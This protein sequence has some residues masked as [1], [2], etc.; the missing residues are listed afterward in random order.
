MNIKLN[1]ILLLIALLCLMSSCGGKHD[2]AAEEQKESK[3][4]KS[5]LQ[6]VWVDAE[7]ESVAFMVKGDTI[8]YPDSTLMP[9]C[10][11]I[12]GDTL[13]LKGG[14]T[15]KYGIVKQSK[16]IFSFRNG[17]G[18][19]IKLVRSVDEEQDLLLFEHKTVQPI[20]QGVKID[21]DSIVTAG[22]KRYHFYTTVNPTSFKVLKRTFNDDGVEVD[23]VYYDNIV[24]LSVFDGNTKVFSGDFRKDHFAQFIE[25]YNGEGLILSDINYIGSKAGALLFEAVIGEPDGISNYVV[26]I[27]IDAKGKISIGG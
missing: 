9:V 11:V 26:S 10:F 1:R 7:S 8:F 20:N 18:E 4:A 23:N 21:R 17:V 22:D 24:H 5:L 15:V 16:N 12:Y 14:T 3:E 6:G 27:I 13:V 19:E 2:Q 25:G